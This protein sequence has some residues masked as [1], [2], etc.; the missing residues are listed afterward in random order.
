MGSFLDSS[1]DIRQNKESSSGQAYK[2][3][4]KLEK[5]QEQGIKMAIHSASAQKMERVRLPILSAIGIDFV[6]SGP[7]GPQTGRAELLATQI[8]PGAFTREI[9]HELN[10]QI[11]AHYKGDFDLYLIHHS[12]A[13][14]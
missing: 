13:L 10:T 3:K 8:S 4:E 14:N 11:R 5:E 6:V 12:P 7:V 1:E 2:I 9:Y